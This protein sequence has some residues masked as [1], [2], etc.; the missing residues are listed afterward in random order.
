MEVYTSK[1]GLLAVSTH[2]ISTTP[3][4]EPQT[5]KKIGFWIYDFIHP[6]R[7]RNSR[8]IHR[9]NDFWNPSN[10]PNGGDI[11]RKFYAWAAPGLT[12]TTIAG[13]AFA[14]WRLEYWRSSS[15]HPSRFSYFRCRFTL[16]RFSNSKYHL[17]VILYDIIWWNLFTFHIVT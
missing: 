7:R 16:S 3:N 14:A 8:W 4:G 13:T 17:Q 6:V 12:K 9:W 15:I 11:T 2:Q 5:R 1:V 10:R